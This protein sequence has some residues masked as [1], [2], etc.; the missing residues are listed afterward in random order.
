[1]NGSR[2][3]ICHKENTS[4]SATLLTSLKCCVGIAAFSSLRMLS[5]SQPS[6]AE[7]ILAHSFSVWRDV[8]Q[9]YSRHDFRARPTN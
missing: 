2:V 3:T 4:C 6:L 5:L 1:M 9:Q 8:R 7:V